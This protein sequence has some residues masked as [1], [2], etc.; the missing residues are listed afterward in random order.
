MM[1][2]RDARVTSPLARGVSRSLATRARRREVREEMY[3][4]GTGIDPEAMERRERQ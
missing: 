3:D 1:R 2:F 4:S